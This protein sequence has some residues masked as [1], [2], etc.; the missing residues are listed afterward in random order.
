MR[1]PQ[2]TSSI[3]PTETNALKPTFSRRLQSRIAVHNAP[4]WLMNPTLPGSAMLAAKVAL[5]PTCGRITPRQ[6]GPMIR[7]LPRRACARTCFSSSTPASPHS[8]KPAEIM[9]APLAPAS[10]HSP[11]MPGTVRGRRNDDCEVDR[12]FHLA[13]F[14]NSGN[15]EHSRP[16]EIHWNDFAAEVARFQILHQ[17]APDAAFGFRRTNHRHRFRREHCFQSRSTLPK[18][19]MN[20]LQLLRRR[21]FSSLTWLWQR[22]VVRT[23]CVVF[24]VLAADPFLEAD[25]QRR[26]QRDSAHA[27]PRGSVEWRGVEGFVHERH[28][29]KRHWGAIIAATPARSERFE[30]APS[31]RRTGERAAIEEPGSIHCL[32]PLK[33]RERSAND[34]TACLHASIFDLFTFRPRDQRDSSFLGRHLAFLGK[35][36]EEP[37]KLRQA[38]VQHTGEFR[39]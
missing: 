20:A 24:F 30:N 33:G 29:G 10:T 38:S 39:S 34:T 35:K 12:M 15:A 28:V 32:Q 36:R 18:Y 27:Q 31:D 5:R 4:L 23:G 9:I 16:L 7:I 8:L 17:R 3:E 19:I 6:F 2:F 22:P 13:D 21:W 1:S 25:N 14:R 37:D 26:G 11:M